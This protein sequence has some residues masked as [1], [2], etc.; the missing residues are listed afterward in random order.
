MRLG[1]LITAALV[2][3]T[4]ALMLT[5]S[6]SAGG[7]T[8]VDTITNDGGKVIF[9]GGDW[10][11]EA[12]AYYNY[13]YDNKV[14]NYNI[15]WS[16]ARSF[17]AIY[18]VTD[19]TRTQWAADTNG[20]GGDDI[21]GAIPK[22]GPGFCGEIS[23]ECSCNNGQY[24]Y[25]RN[26]VRFSGVK[27][28]K[29]GFS[30]IYVINGDPDRV[31]T[32]AK[33]IGDYTYKVLWEFDPADVFAD[34]TYSIVFSA[35]ESSFNSNW[36]MD[37]IMSVRDANGN[38][39][40]GWDKAGNVHLESNFRYIPTG[41]PEPDASISSLSVIR[42]NPEPAHYIGKWFDPTGYKLRVS[43]D[44][45]TYETISLTSEM[46]SDYS[47]DMA[48]KQAITVTYGG[49]KTTFDVNFETPAI[50][51]ISVYDQPKT[52]FVLGEPFTTGDGSLLVKFDD[53]SEMI[54]LMD[55]TAAGVTVNS[56]AYA[57]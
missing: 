6:A 7:L 33:K 46:L 35:K 37:V 31:Y 17:E 4:A 28:T 45:G 27:D 18:I 13:E 53:G 26:V 12:V 22:I 49:V 14:V 25:L 57:R 16:K 38:N 52:E 23:V 2:A 48:G 5:I 39:L 21:P 50:E 11:R 44:D 29:L 10:G 20:D 43:Y 8:E 24:S 47:K 55:D 19:D 15:D 40:I 9:R 1:K 41:D 32:K 54:V 3:V 30:N 42:P 56:T 36:K 34:G 51:S